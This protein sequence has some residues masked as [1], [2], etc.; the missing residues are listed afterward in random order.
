MGKNTESTVELLKKALDQK[1]G[2][3]RSYINFE[4]GHLRVDLKGFLTSDRGRK[5]FAK[6]VE[7]AQSVPSAPSRRHKLGR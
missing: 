5:A 2:D 7:A 3:Q 4:N 6:E 1:F